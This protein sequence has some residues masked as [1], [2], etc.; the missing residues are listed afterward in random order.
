M[1]VN[2]QPQGLLQGRSCSFEGWEFGVAQPWWGKGAGLED[3]GISPCAEQW[4]HGPMG[5]SLASSVCYSFSIWWGGKASHELG[6]Q[7]ADVSALPGALPQSSMS[8]ASYQSLWIMEVRRSCG[9]VLVA[10]LDL[11][12]SNF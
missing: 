12:P 4:L 9:C 1:S 8:P 11:Y 5:W 3:G 10:I 7:S 6:V 2:P